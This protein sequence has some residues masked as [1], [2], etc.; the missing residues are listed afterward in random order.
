MMAYELAE[1]EKRETR[2]RMAREERRLVP[3]D[4]SSQLDTGYTGR[5]SGFDSCKPWTDED[6]HE[7]ER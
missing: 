1:I 3:V 2:Y 4:A 5:P 7:V 6:G